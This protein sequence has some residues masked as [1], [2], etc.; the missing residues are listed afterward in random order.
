MHGHVQPNFGALLYTVLHPTSQFG[1]MLLFA[2]PVL[3]CLKH[4]VYHKLAIAK[5]RLQCGR[6]SY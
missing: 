2:H 4:S 3:T 6:L 5:Q 1:Y